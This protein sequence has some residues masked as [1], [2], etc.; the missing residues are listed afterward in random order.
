MLDLST[1]A[2][3]RNFR[4]N[5]LS[6]FY[7]IRSFLPSMLKA[8]NG[9]TIVTVASVLGDLSA[10]Y[11]SDYAAAK[12]GLI[13]M[14]T[15]LRAEMQAGGHE[16]IKTILV[17]PGQLST[18]LFEGVETPSSFL[19]PVVDPVHLAREIVKKIDSGHSGVIG[20]PL[21]VNYIEWISVLPYG[22][23][24]IVRSLGGIDRAMESFSGR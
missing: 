23:Q 5:L 22:L 7:T 19:G 10:A 16:K 14:H 13:A 6:H 12:A 4:V 8:P 20:M 18:P 3:E 9:G 24:S 15:S 17:K 1:P 21:Y 11:L 2:L